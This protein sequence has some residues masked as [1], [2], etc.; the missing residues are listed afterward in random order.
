PAAGDGNSV[1]SEQAAAS[2]WDDSRVG[3][4]YADLGEISPQPAGQGGATQGTPTSP[5]APGTSAAPA[6]RADSPSAKMADELDGL[7]DLVRSMG[8]DIPELPD[9]DASAFNAR[10]D[11]L[12]AQ[13]ATA[14]AAGLA[15]LDA[16][17]RAIIAEYGLAALAL[18]ERSPEVERATEFLTRLA[19]LHTRHAAAL[20][21]GAPP[22]E[23]A[24]GLDALYAEYGLR[25]ARRRVPAARR[26]AVR[27]VRHGD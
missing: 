6:Q 11:A 27:A 25:H 23:P 21:A 22:A 2:L 20:A 1:R 19:A 5:A 13:R 24:P 3:D 16:Q 9:A 10:L 18:A 15:R 4:Q 26:R 7:S 14:D 12:I 17:A 8:V